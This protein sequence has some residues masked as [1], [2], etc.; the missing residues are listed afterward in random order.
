MTNYTLMYTS[1]FLS[2][3]RQLIK[4]WTLLSPNISPICS[5]LLQASLLCQEW[6][7]ELII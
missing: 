6:S 2:T 5:V 3:P 7:L 4:W 1:S